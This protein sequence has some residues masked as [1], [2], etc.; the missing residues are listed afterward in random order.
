V[1]RVGVQLIAVAACLSIVGCAVPAVIA[2]IEH[3]KVIV[4]AHEFMTD[5]AAVQAEAERGC[6][7]H[8]RRAVPISTRPAG[9]FVE[10]H[11]FACHDPAAKT[12]DPK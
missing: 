7:L 5:P 6:A 11:L 10:L 3:D 8:G 2:D 9:N 12:A 1:G 4:Q